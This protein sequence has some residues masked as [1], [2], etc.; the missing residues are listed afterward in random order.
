MEIDQGQDRACQ[1]DHATQRHIKNIAAAGQSR[2]Q[3]KRIDGT[4]HLWDQG[5][6]QCTRDRYGR[7]DTDEKGHH[8]ARQPGQTRREFH[9]DQYCTQHG[10][11][12][13]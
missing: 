13:K 2:F 12:Q 6:A 11:E 1:S 7:A 8:W 5:T 9:Q 4:R 3:V 10:H